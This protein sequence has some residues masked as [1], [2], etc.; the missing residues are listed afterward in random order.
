MDV[1]F[2]ETAMRLSDA[3]THAVVHCIP[4]PPNITAKAPL[5]FKKGIDDAE[6]EWSQHH[7]KRMI[8]TGGKVQSLCP[9]H[10]VLQPGVEFV[11]GSDQME[12][13]GN[14][15]DASGAQL[16]CMQSNQ[17]LT[18]LCRAAM[19]CMCCVCRDVARMPASKTN[20][21][22]TQ[23]HTLPIMLAMPAVMQKSESSHEL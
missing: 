15:T 16:L 10:A 13:D 2:M 7:A 11:C 4:V 20:T 22:G 14:L 1:I 23:V 6:S 5:Y 12:Y 21:T 18:N 3:R 9:F 8:E 19:L 17:Q